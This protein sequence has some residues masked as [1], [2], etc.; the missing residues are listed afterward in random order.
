MIDLKLL[1]YYII[2]SGQKYKEVARKIGITYQGL[3]KKLDGKSEFTVTEI[4]ALCEVLE[5]NDDDTKIKI[6]FA[7]KCD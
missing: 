2:M 5:L 1:E 4:N 6:F 7:E 3:R